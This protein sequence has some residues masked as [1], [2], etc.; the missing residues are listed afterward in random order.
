M[1]LKK[2]EVGDKVQVIGK[3]LREW[4]GDS[5]FTII[6]SWVNREGGYIYEIDGA[7]ACPMREEWLKKAI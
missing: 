4:G 5:H 2:F 7:E 3:F 1:K 6:D